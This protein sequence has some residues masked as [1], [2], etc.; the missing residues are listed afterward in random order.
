MTKKANLH[1]ALKKYFGF[2][3]FKGERKSSRICWM[4]KTPLC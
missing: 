4:A 3:K 1:E 2:D